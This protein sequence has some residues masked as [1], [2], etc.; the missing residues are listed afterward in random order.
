MVRTWRSGQLKTLSWGRFRYG[1]TLI[2]A[3]AD[4]PVDAVLERH[5]ML[6]GEAQAHWNLRS[7]GLTLTA[8]FVTAFL[9]WPSTYN[10]FLRA[11]LTT[12]SALECN[13]S[14]WRA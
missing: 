7:P 3:I 5:A 12:E 6:Y 8:A 2:S 9:P 1:A 11:A 4:R 14:C 10:T 13:V